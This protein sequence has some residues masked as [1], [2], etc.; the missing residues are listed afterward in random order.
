V[1]NVEVEFVLQQVESVT[2]TLIVQV[3]NVE[4]G[5]ARQV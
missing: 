5:I 3:E 2:Q 4:V 1:E